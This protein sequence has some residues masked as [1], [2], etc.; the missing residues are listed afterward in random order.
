MDMTA[1]FLDTNVLVYAFAE[2]DP[3]RRGIARSLAES[4]DALISTQ[5]LSELANVLT[6]RM[7]FSPSETR[8]R[9]AGIAASCEVMMVTPSVVGD[10]LRIME[11]YQYSFHDS[12]ILA[13]ALGAGAKVLYS[14][15]LQRE[16][17]IDGTL[18]IRSPFRMTVQQRGARYA[19]KRRGRRQGAAR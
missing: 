11:R 6:R 2:D 5:V 12:Q 18:T 1:Y 10:A 15:D 4:G 17:V 9:V 8:K 13:A 19:V 16:Q 7:G 3:R 14:E